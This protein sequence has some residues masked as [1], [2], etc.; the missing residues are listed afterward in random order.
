[1]EEKVRAGSALARISHRN[2]STTDFTEYTDDSLL[3]FISV[4]SVPSVVRNADWLNQSF[5]SAVKSLRNK[6]L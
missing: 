3:I 5:D 6:D 1:M 2:E 4:N